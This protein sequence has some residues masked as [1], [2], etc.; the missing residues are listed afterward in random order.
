MTRS[1][2]AP[3][4]TA[5]HAHWSH[6]GAPS[7]RRPR[8]RAARGRKMR[9]FHCIFSIISLTHAFDSQTFAPSTSLRTVSCCWSCSDA[10]I[11]SENCNKLEAR[12]QNL[13][14]IHVASINRITSVSEIQKQSRMR[15]ILS[16]YSI[17]F[18]FKHVGAFLLNERAARKGRGPARNPTC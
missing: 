2:T 10:T 5:Q 15:R 9:L 3:L 16:G 12:K 8:R 13:C 17:F 11:F 4:L 6:P 7:Q 14:R 1:V 18:C